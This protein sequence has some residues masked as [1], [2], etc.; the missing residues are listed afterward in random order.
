MGRKM[1]VRNIIIAAAGLLVAA[2]A[3]IIIVIRFMPSSKEADLVSYYKLTDASEDEMAIILRDLPLSGEA[4]DEERDRLTTVIS[5]YRAYRQDDVIY[6]PAEMV[7]TYL[8]ERFYYDDNDGCLVVTNATQMIVAYLDSTSYS[9]NGDESVDTGYVITLLK[10]EALYIAMDFV[11]LYSDAYYTA[12]EDPGRVVIDYLSEDADYCQVSKDTAIREYGGIKSDVIG[13]VSEG[14]E[15]QVKRTL[16]GWYEVISADGYVGYVKANAVSDV[17]VK[18][19]VSDYD[20]PEYTALSTGES[21]KMGWMAVY[22]TAANSNLDADTENAAGMNVIVPTWYT[23]TSV[24]GDLQILSSASMVDSAHAKG[25]LVWAMVSDGDYEYVNGTLSSTAIRQQV[26]DTIMSDMSAK[27]IDG[28]NIDFERVTDECGEDFIQFIRELS[29]RCRAEG[30]YLTVDNYAPYS[31]RDCYHIDE[32]S[33]LCDYVVVMAYDDYV[34]TDEQGPN[35]SLSFVQTVT[36]L[37][38]SKVDNEKLV[39]ALPFYSRFWTENSEGGYDARTYYMSAAWERVAQAGV[40]AV[41]NSESGVYEAEFVNSEGYTV[42]AY[43]ESTETFEA[44]L[45]LLSGYDLAGVAGWRLGQEMDGI[46][47][48]IASYY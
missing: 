36:E 37:A 24:S 23:L 3:A 47:D 16:D 15:L 18:D 46:W 4:T 25:Y 41:W 20:E 22:N 42:Y 17:Y 44:K 28:P 32:Q 45:S 11:D 48:V 30:K 38:L 7:D 5:D 6:V 29:I 1:P 39:I 27:G 13:R 40:E 43:L 14:D 34:G 10:D 35:S 9:I 26:I 8:D 21:V 12:Y 19:E 31:S 33:K 2:I